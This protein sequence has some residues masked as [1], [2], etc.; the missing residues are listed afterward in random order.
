MRK[1]IVTAVMGYLAYLIFTTSCANPGVPVGGDK[2]T[3]APVVLKTL[4]EMDGVNFKGKAVNITF[5]EF[6]QSTDVS[7]ALVVSPPVK[8]KPVVR[9]KSKTLILDFGDQLKPETSYSLDFKNSIADNNEKNPLVNYRMAF[10]TGPVLD[11]LELGGYVRMA[12]NMEPVK[13]VTVLLHRNDSLHFFR[14]SIPDYISKTDSA[15]FFK[16]TNLAAGAYRMYALLDADNSLTFNSTDELIAF[17]DSLV[18][19]EMPLVPD[20]TLLK[21]LAQQ[22][23]S[24]QPEQKQ[25]NTFVQP[26]LAPHYLLLFEEPSYKQYLES[27]KRDRANLCTFIFDEPLTDSFRLDLI[28]PKATPDWSLLEFS[29]KRDTLN[30][31]IRDTALS[32]IDTLKLALGYEVLDSM[33]QMVIQTDTVDMYFAK[34]EVKEKRRKKEDEKV[35]TKVPNFSFKGNGKDG[36]DVY[37]KFLLEVPEP[38]ES[39]DFSKIHLSQKVDTLW[40]NREFAVEA[41]SVNL[42][43]YRILHR[44]DFEQEYQLEI[45]SAAAFSIGAFPSSPFKQR[46]KVKEEGY[47]AKIVLTISKLY[48]PSFVQLL[49]N[50]DKEEVVQQLAIDKDGAIE[51]PYLAPEKF[52]IR[53]VIDPN[54]NGKW[55]S[56]NISE[57]LQPERVVYYPKILKMRSNFQIEENWVLPDDLQFKKEL[58]D[59]DKDANDKKQGSRKPSKSGPTGRTGSR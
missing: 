23:D 39:F 30:V 2:D 3:I 32:Q 38:L 20:S 5:D 14:D 19:P 49:K 36:F 6:I 41:D 27:S 29:A 54:Q 56:G 45:D 40:E 58:I 16:L 37:S 59:E 47:Y 15:G 35:E 24:L 21:H 26:E 22:G 53:L 4:P 18:V 42:R 31:W 12:E 46:L 34:P 25:P 10:S 44:W 52:K 17:S 13:D 51:F 43:R 48:G 57:G 50:T 7:E 11:S 33:Q 1:F 28:S 8:K 55:D 9:T